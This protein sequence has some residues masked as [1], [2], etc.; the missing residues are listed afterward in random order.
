MASDRN[1]MDCTMA[2]D[3]QCPG[4]RDLAEYDLDY[5]YTK[6]ETDDE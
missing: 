5:C 2:E 1:P 6:D 3:C 4:C